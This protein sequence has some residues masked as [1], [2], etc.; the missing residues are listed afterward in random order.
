[1]PRKKVLTMPLKKLLTVI[2]KNCL[3]CDEKTHY[4]AAV[5]SSYRVQSSNPNMPIELT[6][7][8]LIFSGTT[9]TPDASALHLQMVAVLPLA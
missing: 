5:N 3:P 9:H 7:Y 2:R 1:M 6:V 4:C 8:P